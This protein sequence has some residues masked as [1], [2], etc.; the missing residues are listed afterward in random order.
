MPKTQFKFRYGGLADWLAFTLAPRNTS[1]RTVFI[2]GS[3]TFFIAFGVRLFY[4][5]DVRSEIL[6]GESIITHLIDSY[7]YE[8]DRIASGGGW[9]FPNEPLQNGDAR[10]II[11]APGYSLLIAALYRGNPP[12]RSYALIRLIQ[13]TADSSAAVLVALITAELLPTIVALLAGLLVAFSPHL[14]FYSLWLT[15]DSLA[16]V[17]IL[18]A[19]LLIIRAGRSHR[20]INIISAGILIGLSCLLRS[21]A[22]LLA[23]FLTLVILATFRPLSRALISASL[24]LGMT[25]LVILPFTIRNLIVFG[26]F[27]PLSLGGG[28]TL[29]EGVADYDDQGKFNLPIYDE[30]VQIR[31]AEFFGRPDYSGDLW[32]PDGV[33]RDRARF[34]QAL[35]AIRSDVPGFIVVMLRRMAFMLRYNDFLPQH[36]NSN[37][38]LAPPVAQGP[39]FGHTLDT[40]Y[41]REPVL[42]ISPTDV[43]AGGPSKSNEARLSLVPGSGLLEVQGDGSQ[44]REQIALA[45]FDLQKNT[46]YRVDIPVLVK[47]GVIDIRIRN[48]DGRI[49]LAQVTIKG[50]KPN[51]KKASRQDIGFLPDRIRE[52]EQIQIPF[53]SQDEQ[54]AYVTIRNNGRELD[55]PVAEIGQV[56]LFEVGSTPDTWTTYP[57]ALTRAIQKNLF[58]TPRMRI[59]I[60]LGIL[61]FAVGR[62]GHTLCILLAVPAYYLLLQS[63]FHTEYRYI[64]VIHYFLFIAAS[65]TIYCSVQAMSIA[66]K[67]LPGRS[68][69]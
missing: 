47:S 38:T 25:A 36:Q 65:T 23:P 40:A 68:R 18:I 55:Y 60:L 44:S 6:Y 20:L 4:L 34:K 19:V 59:L 3:V 16:V 69:P 14:G 17:P 57:R 2:I 54:Q 53:A 61:L 21:N 9:L 67:R 66:L 8:A 52:P 26:T 56:Q 43:L 46:D 39:G 42:S 24:L 31:E 1:V 7:E 63:V 35:G 45:P 51:R 48:E 32:M 13:I 30:D 33:A 41:P 10:M 12:D 27:I 22:L 5:Q 28:V 64:L 49:T 11:H 50:P 62:Q 15:P 29:L 58:T 37:T